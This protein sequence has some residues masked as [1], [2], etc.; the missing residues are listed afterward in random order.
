[1]RSDIKRLTPPIAKKGL[2]LFNIKP[3]LY[4][5]TLIKQTKPLFPEYIAVSKI[6][7]RV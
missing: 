1:M 4:L 5:K 7:R 2:I 6:K 3:F